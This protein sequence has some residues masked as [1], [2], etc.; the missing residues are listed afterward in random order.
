MSFYDRVADAASR[1]W[2]GLTQEDMAKAAA[3]HVETMDVERL[4][5][6]LETSIPRFDEPT[7]AALECALLEA[8]GSSD[9]PGTAATPA[10]LSELVE[11]AKNLPRLLPDAAGAFLRHNPQ[12][13]KELDP[14]LLEEI[15]SRMGAPPQQQ[16]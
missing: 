4:A 15:K 12:A 13:L 9:R 14:V 11:R 8:M 2:S 3:M 16:P 7:R 10:S 6:A 1:F 5:G